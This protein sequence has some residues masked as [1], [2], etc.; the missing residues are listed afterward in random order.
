MTVTFFIRPDNKRQSSLFWSPAVTWHGLWRLGCVAVLVGGLA[1]G[2]A[3]AQSDDTSAGDT[4]TGD[5]STGDTSADD[6][7]ADDTSAGDTSAGDTSAADDQQAPAPNPGLSLLDSVDMALATSP[8]IKQRKTE[9]LAT[10]DTVLSRRLS[11]LPSFSLSYEFGRNATEYR[12]DDP[13]STDRQ[14]TYTTSSTTGQATLP[15]YSGGLL[16]A[17]QAESEA[18]VTQA[19]LALV[20]T[21]RGIV[22]AVV[23]S[24]YAVLR[25]Q[26]TLALSS[27]QLE[28]MYDLRAKLIENAQL[29]PGQSFLIFR[30]DNRAAL[31]EEE[32]A[33]N[34]A[35]L[36]QARVRL[37]TLTGVSIG[38]VALP[39]TPALETLP[40]TLEDALAAGRANSPRI[41]LAA[42]SIDEAKAA[43][44][45]QRAAG[46]PT[47]SLNARVI[48]SSDTGGTENQTEDAFLGLSVAYSLNL[49]GYADNRAAAKRVVTAELQLA[50]ARGQLDELI[51]VAWHE[52]RSR[53]TRFQALERFLD[54]NAQ[55]LQ[56]Y[57]AQF[58]SNQRTLIDLVNINHEVYLARTRVLGGQIERDLAVYALLN[59]LGQ[60]DEA[61]RALG[62]N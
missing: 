8:L 53:I 9:L 44:R 15:L 56:V 26:E 57:Y 16:S 11:R 24:Y 23:S 43:R 29:D 17:Q 13:A 12:Y 7:S 47:L 33:A 22:N 48:S 27:V 38:K 49:N 20:S 61:L 51:T 30:A 3:L 14:A 39:R 18:A 45:V 5:T 52:Y 37:Q 2:Q 35:S 58:E 10:K 19:E 40:Q 54:A 32:V 42:A 1:T 25:A 6:T 60:T 62:T 59:A 21:E 31:I 46:R 34:R 36:D 28:T 55:E 50:G 41:D 4:S